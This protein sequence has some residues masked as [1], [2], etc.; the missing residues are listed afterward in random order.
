MKDLYIIGGTMGVGKTAVCRRLQKMLPDCVFLDGDWC[1][2]S[3]P[4]IVNDET[5]EVVLDNI[6]GVLNRFISCRSYQS[7]VF[8]RVMHRREIIDTILG[9]L[10]TSDCNVRIISLVCDEASLVERLTGD[11]KRGIRTPNVIK[12]SVERLPLYHSLDTSMVDTTAKTIEQVAD[13]IARL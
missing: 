6:C 1:W 13:E 12:R 4:F 2:N 5:K 3:E 9:R 10:D 7:V 11:V 8:C